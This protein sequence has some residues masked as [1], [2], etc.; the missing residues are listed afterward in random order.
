MEE[1]KGGLGKGAVRQKKFYWIKKRLETEKGE[2]GQVTYLPTKKNLVLGKEERRG[3]R[4]GK[5]RKRP[6]RLCGV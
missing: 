5:G 1:E 6:K 2:R 3:P 4:Y